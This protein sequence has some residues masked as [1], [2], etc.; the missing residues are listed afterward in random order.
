M[1]IIG[2]VQLGYLSIAAALYIVVMI[3]L[4]RTIA[5]AYIVAAVIG[6]VICGLR[7]WAPVNRTL[8]VVLKFSSVPVC[9]AAVVQP[10][11]FLRFARDLSHSWGSESVGVVWNFMLW[12][13]IGVVIVEILWRRVTGGVMRRR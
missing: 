13:A 7:I 5:L 2:A 4:S 12:G 3:D 10:L 1:A 6:I 9:S 11:A 8:N